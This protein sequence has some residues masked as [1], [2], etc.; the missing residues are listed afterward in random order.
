MLTKAKLNIIVNKLKHNIAD[1]LINNR[2]EASVSQISTCA[3]ILYMANQ[4]YY[5]QFLEEKLI[6][7][8]NILNI[9]VNEYPAK[10]DTILFFDSFGLEN[11]GLAQIYLKALSNIGKIIYVT[12]ADYKNKI[13]KLAKIVETNN[14]NKIYYLEGKDYLQKIKELKQI[15]EKEKPLHIINYSTP[16]EV[17]LPIASYPYR[18]FTKRYLINLTDHAFWLGAQLIDY[19]VEFRDYGAFI[20]KKYRNI[21]KKNIVCLPYYP[22]IDINKEFEGFPFPYN[23]TKHRI[24]FSGGNIYKTI[25]KDNLYYKIV[26]YIL[27]NYS[28]VIFWY[29]G[30]GDTLLY[31]NFNKLKE[32]YPNQLFLT[33]ERQD[34]YQVLKSCYFYLSTY[35]VCGGLMMQY[36][37]IAK[38]LPI[39]LK[40]DNLVDDLLINQNNLEIM[41][42]TYEDLIKEINKL[43]KDQSYL[44]SKETKLENSVISENEFQEQLN[45][46]INTGKT[47]YKL[48]YKPVNTEDFRKEYLQ[49]LCVCDVFAH[50]SRNNSL[51]CSFPKEYIVG[52]FFRIINKLKIFKNILGSKLWKN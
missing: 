37:A 14:Q 52:L 2:I 40:L 38:K 26:D 43:L 9:T 11:R 12:Y 5:D 44:K 51:I 31:E 17:S 15:F 25:S 50:I 24:I 32:K 8:S 41:F 48:D 7:I 47:K 4:T 1:E 29:A 36:A 27:S 45:F 18:N 6:E 39:T 35:P 49:R 34:L 10:K 3:R 28:D 22:V 19:C 33:K 23:E 30:S 46:V 20:S 13:P 21:N 16:W 42:D